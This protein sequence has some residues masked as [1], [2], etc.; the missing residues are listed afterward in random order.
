MEIAKQE[1]IQAETDFAQLCQTSGIE[2]AFVK[3]S[4]KNAH[5]LRGDVIYA[6]NAEIKKF[7]SQ[8]RFKKVKLTWKPDFVDVSSS[9]DLGYTYGK[10]VYS[11]VDSIGKVIESTGYFHTVWKKQPNETWRFVWD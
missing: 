11:T 6:G 7:Y 5:I 2:E 8:A 10:Y 1:I 3:F 4:A 9:C